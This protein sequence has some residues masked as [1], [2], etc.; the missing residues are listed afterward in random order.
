MLITKAIVTQMQSTPKQNTITLN[1]S[2][3]WP[4]Q[5]LNLGF[6]LV[7]ERGIVSILNILINNSN[8]QQH[9]TIVHY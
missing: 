2:F 1:P 6:L 5:Q 9:I 4:A 8:N 3:C 7:G